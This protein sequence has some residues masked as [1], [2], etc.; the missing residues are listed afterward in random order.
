MTK[1]TLDTSF[2]SSD[3]L[4]FTTFTLLAVLQP[5]KVSKG[6]FKARSALTGRGCVG[7]LA[8]FTEQTRTLLYSWVEGSL[9]TR[10]TLA[11][12]AFIRKLAFG[13]GFALCRAEFIGEETA[14]AEETFFDASVVDESS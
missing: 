5:D 12:T 9:I 4:C 2:L 10:Q 11:E 3:C 8:A 13:A 7:E 6:S 1:V 14:A